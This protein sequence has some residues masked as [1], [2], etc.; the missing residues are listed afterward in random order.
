MLDM[1]RPRPPHLRHEETRHGKLVWY[2]RKGT[3]PRV[4]LR[5]DYGTEAFWNEY[6]D[7]LA[8]TPKQA[9][10]GAG[11]GTFAWALERYRANNAWLILKPATKRQRENVFKAIL[12]AIGHLPLSKLNTRSIRHARDLRQETPHSANNLVKALRGFFRW[13]VKAELV[14]ADPMK[15]VE[16]LAGGN[17]A[18]GFHTW[19]E[20]ELERFEA[21]WPLGTRER[22]AF[23]LLLYT[24]LRRGDVVKLGRQHLRDGVFTI[25]T[26]KTGEEVYPPLLPP[27][28]ASIAAAKTGD[29]TYLVTDRGKPFVKEG[30]GNWFREACTAAGCPGSAHGLRK[31]GA[32]RA[33]ENGASD[34]TLMAMFGWKTAKMASVYTKAADR[35]RMA[36]AG[37]HLLLKG[38]DGN[39]I[40]RTPIAGAALDT[41]PTKKSAS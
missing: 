26:E 23:D 41:N 4:R 15:G 10:K 18:H 13:A 20:S 40:D 36:R 1:P 17:D 16:L 21:H 6:R 9:G 25:R 8:G 5:A 30:F 37:G 7:A 3:G 31:S 39:E 38:Q 19:S 11:Q 29:L 35:K 12:P 34:R 22:L 2:V 28:A 14:K 33:A 24:G 32:T 27:L